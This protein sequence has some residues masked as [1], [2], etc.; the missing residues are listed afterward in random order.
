MIDVV[1]LEK[2]YILAPYNF[3]YYKLSQSAGYDKC[4]AL[5]CIV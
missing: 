1:A 3:T 5:E 2:E 4:R